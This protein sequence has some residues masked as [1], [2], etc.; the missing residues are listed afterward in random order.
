MWCVGT[1]R[2]PADAEPVALSTG[3]SLVRCGFLV[4]ITDPKAVLICTAFVPQFVDPTLGPVPLQLA[5]LGG[6]YLMAEAVAGSVWIAD[7]APT[8]DSRM[9]RRTRRRV[10]RGTGAVLVGLAGAL[11]VSRG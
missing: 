1:F 5:V 10:D 9:S 7:G 3:R 4:A 2:A 8:G 6:L 11:A